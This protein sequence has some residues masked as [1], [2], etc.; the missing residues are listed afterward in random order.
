MED[1]RDDVGAA[2]VIGGDDVRCVPARAIGTMRPT[3]VGA[4]DIA[5]ICAAAE[6][7]CETWVRAEGASMGP[8]LRAGEPVL[9]APL[10]SP[11]RV[12]DVVV[13][14]LH[15][16]AVLHRVSEVR[17]D[18]IRTRGDACAE[19]DPPLTL[20]DVLAR[21]VAVRRGDHPMPLRWSSRFGARGLWRY[22]LATC[23]AWPVRMARRARLRVRVT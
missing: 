21:A 11:P 17:G 2:E 13:V 10:D 8:T 1:A 5:R 12:G 18:H 22:S 7:G 15:G 9:V 14:A 19:S 16:R 6:R 23:T 20:N 4:Q 3:R